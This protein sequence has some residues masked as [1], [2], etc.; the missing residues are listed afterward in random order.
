VIE[1]EKLTGGLAELPGGIG[2]VESA[3]ER[4]GSVRIPPVDGANA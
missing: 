3:N 1:D 4:H 2:Q